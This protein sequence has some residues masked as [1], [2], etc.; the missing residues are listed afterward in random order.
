MGYKII[1]VSGNDAIRGG[2]IKVILGDNAVHFEFI[3]DKDEEKKCFAIQKH[4]LKQLITFL[5]EEL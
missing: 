2:I 4:N 3:R 5:I 1:E